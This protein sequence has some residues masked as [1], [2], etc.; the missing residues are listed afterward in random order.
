MGEV[1]KRRNRTLKLLE[2]K[3]RR[4]LQ[5]AEADYNNSVKNIASKGELQYHRLQES[6]D[7]T[8]RKLLELQASTQIGVASERSQIEALQYQQTIAQ[9][10]I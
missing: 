1:E 8:F 9:T 10:S 7:G 4:N 2:D 5:L 3:T 6:I